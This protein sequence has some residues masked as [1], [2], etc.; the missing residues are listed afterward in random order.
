MFGMHGLRCGNEP[1]D[2]V[3][4]GSRLGCVN[5]RLQGQS[6]DKGEN[7][8]QVLRLRRRMTQLKA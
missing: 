7:K 4:F 2:F 1:Q 6:Y 5:N 3:L 8:K